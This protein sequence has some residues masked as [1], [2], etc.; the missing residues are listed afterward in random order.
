MASL[1]GFGPVNGGPDG[2]MMARTRLH[3]PPR[4]G[5]VHPHPRKRDFSCRKRDFS[6][7]KRD[8]SCTCTPESPMKPRFLVSPTPTPTLRGGGGGRASGG[9]FAK[10][11]PVPRSTRPVKK[12]FAGK[13]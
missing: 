11:T 3:T 5:A 12:A 1:L 2:M 4:G 10:A 7:R 8:F 6:C 13:S 9:R